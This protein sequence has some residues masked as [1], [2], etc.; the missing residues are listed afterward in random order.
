[1]ALRPVPTR[2]QLWTR[3]ARNLARKARAAVPGHN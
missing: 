1:V 2:R 3:R